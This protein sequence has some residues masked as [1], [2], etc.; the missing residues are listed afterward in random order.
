[1]DI[2]HVANTLTELN[3]MSYDFHGAFSST[4]GT[5]APLYYQGWGEE[6]FSLH[7][8]VENWL[9]GG[10][11]KD[12][13]NIGL[14]FYGR[15]FAGATGLNEPHDGAD[16]AVW[17]VDDGTPQYYNIMAQ[18]PSMVHVWDKQSWT[19]WAYFE[20]GGSVSF[21][22][23]NAICAKTQYA[24]DNDLNGFIIW[25]LSGDLMSDLSTPLLDIVNLK[26][27]NPDYSCGEPGYYPDEVVNNGAPSPAVAVASASDGTTESFSGGT[28][29]DTTTS[30]VDNAQPAYA[31]VSS[32]ST[33]STPSMAYP[34]PSTGNEAQP[35]YVPA[36]A[37]TSGTVPTISN[38]TDP[39]ST[40]LFLNCKDHDNSSNPITVELSFTYELHRHPLVSSSAA[41]EDA[42]ASM[43]NDIAGSF[44][45][46]DSSAKGSSGRSLSN[47]RSNP[48][49]LQDYIVA[50]LSPP[51]DARNPDCK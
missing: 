37:P 36:P 34:I 19:D 10:A 47:L 39:S 28:S 43:L 4:T 29:P 30:S 13:L 15:S 8:C 46:Q 41:A 27:A 14:P 17:S 7:D 9:A 38:P 40:S 21:D 26:L 35:A 11:T 3:L 2:A 49:Q 16:Q 24:L 45:C 31:P 33:D 6:G 22:D 20:S 1:M 42:K 50:I 12:K 48:T 25:E 18:L 23:T 51:F 32:P 5:N 44:W